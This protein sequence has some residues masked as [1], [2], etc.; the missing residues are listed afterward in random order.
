MTMLAV[1]VKPS[2]SITRG[3]SL[4]WKFCRQNHGWDSKYIWLLTKK[5]INYFEYHVY[6]VQFLPESISISCPGD[7]HSKNISIVVTVHARGPHDEEHHVGPAEGV[8]DGAV[9]PPVVPAH[10]EGLLVAW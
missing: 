5:R 9:V 1:M 7:T 6:V 10:Q 2:T 3:L 8:G 4:D